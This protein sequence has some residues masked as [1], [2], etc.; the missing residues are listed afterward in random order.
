MS[1]PKRS[2]PLIGLVCVT[3]LARCA[4]RVSADEVQAGYLAANKAFRAAA[5]KVMPSIVTIETFGGLGGK[6]ARGKRSAGISKP[7][8]GPTTGVII[9]PDGYII[10]STY[11][12]LRRPSVITVVLQDGTQYVAKQLGSDETRKICLLKIDGVDDLPVPEYVAPSELKVGQWAISVGIGYGDSQPAISAGIISALD[13]VFGRAIQTDANISPANYGGPLLDVEGRMIGLCVPLSPM[14]ADLTAGSEW[15]DSGIG[16][17][18]PLHGAEERIAAMREG[19]TIKPGR[20]GIQ[21]KPVRAAE[22][23]DAHGAEIAKV[24]PDSPAAKAN[25]QNGD[26]ITA[27]GDR[28]VLDSVHLRT[29]LGRYVAGNEIK[30]RIKRGAEEFVVP[31]T[32]EAGEEIMA[33]PM[34]PQPI[35]NPA[36]PKPA[37]DEPAPGP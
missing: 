16:F 25:L 36:E 3:L 11:N 13:R 32:L 33:G 35:A 22:G 5:Q 37:D 9:S 29:L 10:T 30:L 34:P 2:V 31:V 26:I 6:A 24:V 17:A 20:M 14:S 28:Q 1:S 21:P 15:Y 8:D 4:A 7:G 12:F 19:E 18:V 23:S 27:V